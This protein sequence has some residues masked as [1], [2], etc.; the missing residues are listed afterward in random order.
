VRTIGLVRRREDLPT[1]GGA[2]PFRRVEQLGFR[3]IVIGSQ[4]GA[5]E[6]IERVRDFIDYDRT[7]QRKPHAF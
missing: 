2:P 4:F 7:G 5:I 1:R 6:E 3:E